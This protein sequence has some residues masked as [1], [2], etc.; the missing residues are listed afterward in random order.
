MQNKSPG[1]R[2]KARDLE[3]S[4][5]TLGLDGAVT[6]LLIVDDPY[7]PDH[8]EDEVLLLVGTSKA[9]VHM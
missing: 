6:A 7:A 4:F 2:N 5:V 1:I 3:P 9:D 8:A